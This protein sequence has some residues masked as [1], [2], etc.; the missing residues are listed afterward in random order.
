MTVST[1]TGGHTRLLSDR[2]NGASLDCRIEL[3]GIVAMH[4][5]RSWCG[6]PTERQG[7]SFVSLPTHWRCSSGRPGCSIAGSPI[8][9]P[10]P[11]GMPRTARSRTPSATA[12]RSTIKIRR[13]SMRIRFILTN[14]TTRCAA[15]SRP[16]GPS[17]RR[18]RSQS[19]IDLSFD[20]RSTL[21]LPHSSSAWPV[22][23]LTG[24]ARVNIS[25]S[26]NELILREICPMGRARRDGR[27]RRWTAVTRSDR[28]S[29]RCGSRNLL[30]GSQGC[31]HKPLQSAWS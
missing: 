11:R 18:R 22:A 29:W 5:G 24:S 6:S 2:I 10:R 31:R 15:P 4:A 23:G 28:T 17:D 30:G 12:S 13:R 21:P 9:S 25:S 1:A 27:D 19:A 8:S 3:R 16:I 7:L 26:T 14:P 20:A